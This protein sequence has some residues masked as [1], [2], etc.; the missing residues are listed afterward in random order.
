MSNTK[1]IACTFVV[2]GA[3]VDK[4]TVG[5]TSQETAGSGIAATIVAN[6][7]LGDAEV[8]FKWNDL[9]R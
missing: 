6:A 3:C 2:L 1:L 9:R 8:E 4:E 5:E 7:L